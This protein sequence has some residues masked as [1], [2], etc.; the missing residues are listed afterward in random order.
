MCSQRLSPPDHALFLGTNAGSTA[1]LIWFYFI[2]RDYQVSVGIPWRNTISRRQPIYGFHRRVDHYAR[3]ALVIRPNSNLY[4]NSFYWRLPA[5]YCHERIRSSFGNCN[6]VSFWSWH[7]NLGQSF[8]EN[9][10]SG[11]PIQRSYCGWI[12]GWTYYIRRTICIEG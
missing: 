6:C 4:F 11:L 10:G 8:K 1:P 9:Q 2:V 5:S 3:H 7:H 12:S